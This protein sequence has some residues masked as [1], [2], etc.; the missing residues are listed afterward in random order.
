MR[1]RYLKK[2][3]PNL[4]KLHLLSIVIPARDEEGCIASTVEHLHLELRLQ[5]VP[6]EIVVVDD[7]S[8]DR[9]WEILYSLKASIPELMPTQNTGEHGFGRAIVWGLDHAR[10]DAVVIMMADESDDCRDVVRYWNLLNDG[11]E[12]VF[13]SRFVKGGGV[14]DYPRHKLFFNRLANR[15]IRTLFRIPLNDTTNAFKA[16]R[17]TVID[18]CRP[19]LAPHFNLTVEIPL[20]AIV[21]GYS[22]TTMPITWRNRRTGEAKLKIKEMGSRY[23]FICMYIW[24]EKYFSRGDYRKH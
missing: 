15:F 23:F 16:Y 8:K 12:C 14:I 9:T 21:R 18:G 20:K 7:G 19:L 2:S 24:L 22:W 11:W 13:G 6:H 10:G 1:G 4:P 17:K 3:D 5:G